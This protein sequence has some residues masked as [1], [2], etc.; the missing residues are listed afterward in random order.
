VRARLL[1]ALEAEPYVVG[2]DA[3]LALTFGIGLASAPEDGA[4]PDVLLAAADLAMYAHK[5]SRRAG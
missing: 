3:S 1:A 5:A 4:T 2:D